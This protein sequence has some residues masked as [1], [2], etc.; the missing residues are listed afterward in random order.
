MS[1][2]TSV[3][4]KDSVAAIVIL[5]LLIFV[6]SGSRYWIY[7]S[8]ALMVV[9]VL[10]PG[11]THLL[12]WIWSS[13]TEFLGRISSFM[14]LAIVFIFV[15]TPTALLKKWFGSKDFLLT[16]GKRVT[17]FQERNHTY[18]RRDFDNPW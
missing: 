7:A 9:T 18:S 12:H 3:K 8:L 4:E 15:L 5:L 10:S 6:Y 16:K 1:Q 14:I 17:T 13:L 2:K 11:M